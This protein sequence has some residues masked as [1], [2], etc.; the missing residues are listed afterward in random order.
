[1]LKIEKARRE[2]KRYLNPLPTSV[3]GPAMLGK[4]L[5]RYLMNREE[6]TPKKPLGPFKTDIRLYAQAPLSGLRIT[7]IGHSSLLLE[8]DGKRVLIDPVWD[9][10]AAPVQWA[11]PRRFFKP[12]APKI[13]SIGCRHP[14][15]A[16]SNS[17]QW[18]GINNPFPPNA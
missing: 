2:G 5:W 1:M 18:I 3:G 10:R 11:G 4:V 8:I 7:W 16:R 9:E 15:K 17:P 12:F 13:R 14:C 6:R